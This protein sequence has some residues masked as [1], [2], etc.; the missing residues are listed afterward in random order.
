MLEIAPATPPGAGEPTGRR[1]SVRTRFEDPSRNRASEGCGPF[2]NT[3]RDQLT[4][5][6]VTH[7]H[8]ESVAESPDAPSR[9][10]SLNTDYLFVGG[11][12]HRRILPRPL[13]SA[14]HEVAGDVNELDLAGANLSPGDFTQSR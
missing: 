1:H 8:D 4:G 5:Q 3:H 6:A 10:G 13:R 11:L 2:A 7:E 14:H 12:E 9:G